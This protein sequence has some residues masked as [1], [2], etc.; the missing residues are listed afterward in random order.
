MIQTSDDLVKSVERSISYTSND[1]Q[2]SSEDILALADE[3]VVMTLLPLITS[4]RGEYLVTS[5][6]ID[7]VKDQSTYPI[8]SRAFARQ[9]RDLKV[10]DDS[11]NERNINIT[12]PE[13]RNAYG[14]TGTPG[15]FFLQGDAI[16]VAPAPS[17]A[18][19]G[20]TVSY[21]LQPSK[22]V[23]LN[24]A[25]TIATAG[26]DRVAG[27][28]VLATQTDKFTAGLKVDLIDRGSGNS[29]LAPDLTVTDVAGTVLTL[30]GTIPT[31]VKDGDYVALAGEAPVVT[32]M[33]QEFY[34]LLSLAVQKR[35]CEAISD[36]D[37]AA[38]LDAKL[39][40]AIQVTFPQM[41]SPRVESV[42]EKVINRHHFLRQGLSRVAPYRWRP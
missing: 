11:G 40:K 16:V 30:S 1:E 12:S 39:E 8:P 21:F 27:T 36:F 10:W 24:E 5:E 15:T 19:G 28:V 18:D 41:L 13:N 6:R 37:H 38:R 17:S 26:I 20:L 2:L 7:F 31:T 4:L 22:L 25:G 34:P 14:L 42:T 23:L 32:G 3:E 9:I 29:I 35:V 33:A